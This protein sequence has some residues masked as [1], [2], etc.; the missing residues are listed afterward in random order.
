[1]RLLLVVLRAGA[2]ETVA[3]ARRCHRLAQTHW[4]NWSL[5]NWSRHQGVMLW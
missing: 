1:V 3:A 4:L 5:L 2:R